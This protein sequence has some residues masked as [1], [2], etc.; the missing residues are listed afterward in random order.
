MESYYN[1]PPSPF[2]PG[3]YI[4]NPLPWYRKLAV[5]VFWLTIVAV[6]CS[7]LM[8]FGYII[9]TMADYEHARVTRITDNFAKYLIEHKCERTGFVGQ[10]PQAIYRCTNGMYLEREIIKVSNPGINI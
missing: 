3:N 10:N 2:G 7:L 4:D 1:P 5:F 9:K 8:G 6:V